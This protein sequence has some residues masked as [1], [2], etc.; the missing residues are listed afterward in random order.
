M[1]L[2]QESWTTEKLGNYVSEIA[3]KWAV[4]GWRMGRGAVIAKGK[5]KHGEWLPWCRQY[6]PD[7]SKD[8]ILRLQKLAE[9]YPD[10]DKLDG[11]RLM[12]AYLEAGIIERQERKTINK[13]ARELEQSTDCIPSCAAEP[14]PKPKAPEPVAVEVIEKD[15]PP[16][17]KSY[18]AQV[19]DLAGLMLSHLEEVNKDE[20]FA[21]VSE[22]EG[23]PA[24]L[25]LLQTALK[26]LG[27][28]YQSEEKESSI[29][30][31]GCDI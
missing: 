13:K 24:T 17:T 18:M 9:T 14:K 23:F 30:R 7:L 4:D 5:L 21:A 16:T 19:Q 10:P 1:H 25:A 11:K 29:K 12:T 27:G 28:P 6:C 3:K 15:D 26:R 22:L 31:A 20:V 8:T 2:P